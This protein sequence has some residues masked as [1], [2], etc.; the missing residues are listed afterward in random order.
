MSDLSRK[1]DRDRLAKRR[2]P[3]WQKLAAGA[4]LGFRA[5]ADT[6]IARWRDRKGKQHYSALDL[7]QADD[8]EGAKR[9]A[10]DWFHQM[11]AA[12]RAPK[13]ATIKEA[14]QAY[15]AD[16][17]RHGR[18]EAAE[19]AE[20]RFKT[21]I[22]GD[23]LAALPL[24]AATRED[25]EEWRERLTQ[26]RAAQST[27]RYVRQTMAALNRAVDDLGYVGN[28]SAW[29]LRALEEDASEDTAVFLDPAQRA[30]LIAAASE[31][32]ALFFRGLELTG[33]RPSELAAAKVKD[34]DTKAGTVRFASRKGK[35]SK[36]RVRYTVLDAEGR[37]FFAEQAKDKLPSAH[38]FT[39]NGS[40]P[41]RR[42]IWASETR[43]AISKHNKAAAKTKGTVRLPLGM[44]AY[45]FR[46]SRISELLQVF[47]VDPLTVA[48]QSGTSIAIIEKNYLRFIPHA[49]QEKLAGLKAAK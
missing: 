26:G 38:L 31:R 47:G 43:D 22:Y 27:N 5:G 40:Q 42:H 2:E 16:L 37:A 39:E 3:H 17:R 12:V 11:G 41:W 9:A 15:L 34:L 1:R 33:A 46:H 20:G 29:Q 8:F 28:A 14:L 30:A 4:Y 48:A 21:T 13:R 24:E 10:E 25:F 35:T 19:T 32:A 6:W 36:L 7:V 49:L 45:A 44:G 23:A 18:E